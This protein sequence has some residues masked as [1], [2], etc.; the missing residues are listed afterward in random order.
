[1]VA[2]AQTFSKGMQQCFL[3]T[4]S[5]SWLTQYTG[6]DESFNH[7]IRCLMKKWER[8]LNFGLDGIIQEWAAEQFGSQDLGGGQFSTDFL[9]TVCAQCFCP[10]EVC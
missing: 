2:R 5:I 7:S 8:T 6:T 9:A 10:A 1:M 3:E 4:V